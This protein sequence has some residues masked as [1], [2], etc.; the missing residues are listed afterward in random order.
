MGIR[1]K[2]TSDADHALESAQNNL[3]A[4]QDRAPI[5][6]RLVDALETW[7][8]QHIPEAIVLDFSTSSDK[9]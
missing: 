2:V 4:A 1:P 9:S 7:R 8:Q 3:S 5:V 6:E